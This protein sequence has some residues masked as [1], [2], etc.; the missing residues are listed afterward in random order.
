MLR[1]THLRGRMAPAIEHF[2]ARRLRAGSAPGS[3]LLFGA[4]EGRGVSPAHAELRDEGGVLYVVDMGSAAGTFVNGAPIRKQAIRS[5]DRVAVGGADGPEFRVEI[6]PQH[7]TGPMPAVA[8]GAD[9]DGR[10]DLATAE[11]IVAEAV[12]RETAGDD[13]TATVVAAK[14]AAAQRRTARYNLA[15]TVGLSVVFVSMVVTAASIWRSHAAVDSLGKDI[16]IDRTP[17]V[18]PKSDIPTRVLSGRE[19][20]DENKSA[21]YVIGWQSGNRYGGVCSGFAIQPSVIAT[22]AHC[23]NAFQGKGGNPIV[24]QNESGGRVRYRILAAQK[25]PQY[26]SGQMSAGSPDVGLIRIDGRMPKTVTLAND[27]EIRSLGPGDDAFVLGFPGRVMDPLSPSATFLQGHVGRLM[28]FGE[29]APNGVE[30]A[31]LIQHD[32]VTRGGNSGSPIFNQYG[33]VIGV[34]AAHLDEEKEVQVG[35]QKTTVVGTSPYRIGMRI[36]LLHGVP[37]P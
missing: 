26:K 21:L 9:A 17:V 5:G 34:H 1:I 35:G 30:D 20:Y 2:A 23:V 27:A 3:E 10:V 11:R 16:G 19:I 37:A 36:D 22:N 18:R 28:A 31:V 32:A 14:V 29:A 4:H 24:T 25:H 13:K 7:P 33:H 8:A 6:L 12:R 15:L